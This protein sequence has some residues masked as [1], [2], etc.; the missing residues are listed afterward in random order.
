MV[1]TPGALALKC[2]ASVDSDLDIGWTGSTH[3]LSFVGG[4]R[5]ELCLEDCTTDATCHVFGPAAGSVPDA[6][7]FG[8][9]L[10]LLSATPL[11]LVNRLDGDIAT[12]V[13]Y[14]TGTITVTVRILS[15]IYV[16]SPVEV[17]PQYSGDEVG[18]TGSCRGGR[19]SDK[20]CTVGG[21]VRVDNS[22]PFGKRA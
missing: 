22:C 12:T 5:L 13:D 16:T 11:C 1:A 20:P 19:N 9:P 17:C 6:A 21:K 2:L 4:G 14:R 10:P 15:D 18:A 8:A 3:N 7:L